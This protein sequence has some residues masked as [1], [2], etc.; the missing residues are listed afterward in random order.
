MHSGSYGNESLRSNIMSRRW[1]PLLYAVRG[2]T[3]KDI[4][5]LIWKGA[6]VNSISTDRYEQPIV[7]VFDSPFAVF[8]CC[9]MQWIGLAT[10]LLFAKR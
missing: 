8:R 2:G 7:V 3:L 10:L 5:F 6:N 9:T 4:D 1:T